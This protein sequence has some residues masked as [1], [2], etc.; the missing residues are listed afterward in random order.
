MKDII[1]FGAGISGLTVAHELLERGFN[2][3]IYE[4]KNSIGGLARSK[5]D[6]NGKPT[7]HS[8]RAYGYFYNN[9]FELIKRIPIKSNNGKFMGKSVI[10]NLTKD[11]ISISLSDTIKKHKVTQWDI[12][13]IGY[14]ILQGITSNKRREIYK[15][16]SFKDTVKDY[17][18]GDAYW[19]YIK[20]KV[21]LAGLDED[22]TSLL[23]ITKT[24][25][26]H[27]VNNI[28]NFSEIEGWLHM[29]KPTSEAWF[30]PWFNYLSILGLKLYLNSELIR[31]IPKKTQSKIYS[32]ISCA[33]VKINGSVRV[34]GDQN[35]IFI[36][37]T[38]PFSFKNT[39]LRSF[40]LNKTDKSILNSVHLVK[41][42]SFDFIT[43]LIEFN[44]KIN[45]GK[46]NAVGFT[47]SEF[48]LFFSTQDKIFKND[49][50][51]TK[52]NN[53]FWSG[54]L[55]ETR[56]KGKLFNKLPKEMSRSQ[57]DKE[58]KHQIFRSQEF[59]NLIEK[60]NDFPFS[61]LKIINMTMWSEW[62]YKNGVLNSDEKNWINSII[63]DKYRPDQ[64]TIFNNL[65]ITG[66]ATST[67]VSLGSME[68][69]V[70]SGKIVANHITH[71][72]VKLFTHKT[73]S[74][75]IPFQIIDDILYDLYLPNIVNFILIICFI[76]VVVSFFLLEKKKI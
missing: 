6:L 34:I 58:I 53:S 2:V 35:T 37:S 14:H 4:K 55:G 70:E 63:T 48:N 76:I 15:S 72:D 45:L 19:T 28:W 41:R 40:N 49:T 21:Y 39:I 26:R 9:L 44:K 68:S 8:F 25:E 56:V 7:E 46:W 52:S 67:S 1:I 5:R 66:T 47:D 30:I 36:N 27:L 18:S 20:S 51:F 13:Y 43:F 31:Y 61:E 42:G 64:K 54:G 38:D 10:D 12:I 69:A 60:Y 74:Y 50:Y 3:T 57:L 29:N 73:P 75:F 23:E 11:L 17:I 33:L 65:Y 24:A 71:G 22:E 32:N 62:K 16:Q 59:K